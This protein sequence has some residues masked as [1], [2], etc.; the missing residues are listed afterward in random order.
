MQDP[1]ATVKAD[2]LK[3]NPQTDYFGSHRDNICHRCFS[4]PRFYTTIECT[5][6]RESE[7]QRDTL[8][9]C[10]GNLRRARTYQAD[11]TR[12]YLRAVVSFE[13]PTVTECS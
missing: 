12:D 3:S 7:Y 2:C 9:G 6:H 11:G 1:H 8:R 4:V 5:F 13:R 10:K